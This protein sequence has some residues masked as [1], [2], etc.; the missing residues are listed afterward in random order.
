M[1]KELK[2]MIERKKLLRKGTPEAE[3]K[4]DR[5]LEAVEK[6]GGLTTEEILALTVH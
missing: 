2:L 6:L 3:A 1:R 5:I 4:A